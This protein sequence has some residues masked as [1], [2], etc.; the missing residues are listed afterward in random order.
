VW[1]KWKGAVECLIA[2]IKH[3]CLNPCQGAS[4]HD[5]TF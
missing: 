2:N 4:G 1:S 5:L 3:T